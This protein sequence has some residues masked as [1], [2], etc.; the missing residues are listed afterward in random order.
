MPRG[1]GEP[2]LAQRTP[3]E[4]RP[5]TLKIREKARKYH[6]LPRKSMFV[7]RKN[8]TASPLYTQRFATLVAV[9][10]GVENYARNEDRGEQ[11]CQQTEAQGYRK[12]SHWAGSEQKQD[13]GGYDGRDVRVND[14][15]PGFTEP[16]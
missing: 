4:V 15:D 12:T 8:S 14:R 2:V 11:V 10:D 3:I 16:L 1:S 7:L 6:F 5:A 13:N 9:E